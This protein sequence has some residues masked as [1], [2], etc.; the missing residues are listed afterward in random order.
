MKVIENIATVGLHAN[1][2]VEHCPELYLEASQVVIWPHVK[3]CDVSKGATVFQASLKDVSIIIV[4]LMLSDMIPYKSQVYCYDFSSPFLCCLR[5]CGKFILRF[6]QN[7]SISIV[8]YIL[9][10][11]IYCCYS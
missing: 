8:L 3:A 9:L 10:F 2:P 5:L 4:S 1:D 6:T 11:Y 7:C